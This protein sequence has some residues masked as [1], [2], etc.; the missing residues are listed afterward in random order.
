MRS[1]KPTHRTTKDRVN[2][3]PCFTQKIDVNIY[4]TMFFGKKFL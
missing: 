3:L 1:G 4:A 2:V